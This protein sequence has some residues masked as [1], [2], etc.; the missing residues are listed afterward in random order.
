MKVILSPH[1]IWKAALVYLAAAW[2]GILLVD[3]LGLTNITEWLADQGR[4]PPFLWFWL[5]SEAHLTEFLQWSTLIAGLIVCARAYSCT[6]SHFFLVLAC[7]LGLMVLEDAANIRHTLSGWTSQLLGVT[8]H[9]STVR[10]TTEFAFYGLL[11][12]LM[13]YPLAAQ[14]NRI[15]H[16]GRLFRYAVAA[17]FAYGSAAFLSA[18]RYIA[19][20]YDAAGAW[21]IGR[22]PL[23][24][25]SVWQAADASL[26]ERGLFPLGFWLM[27]YWLEESLELLAASL[28]LSFVLA[29]ARHWQ[30]TKS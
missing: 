13:L 25:P 27:D 15:R 14:W 6:R 5:F 10:I 22:L 23:A 9:R 3:I 7:G 8:E 28:L 16:N 2:A 20:W 4:H 24:D 17:Y 12:G 18:S 30:K 29:C 19:D 21:I 26:Q 11:G 1:W